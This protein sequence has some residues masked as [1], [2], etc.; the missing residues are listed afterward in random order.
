MKAVAA[1]CP[2]LTSLAVSSCGKLT[3][4]AVK[5][6]AAGCNPPLSSPDPPLK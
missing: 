4:E 1:G 3:D 6:V 5:A 2:G